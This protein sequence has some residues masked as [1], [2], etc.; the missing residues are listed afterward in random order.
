VATASRISAPECTSLAGLMSDPQVYNLVGVLDAEQ[1]LALHEWLPNK[2]CARC[3]GTG[4]TIRVLGDPS[5]GMIALEV[6]LDDPC[7]CCLGIGHHFVI[8]L[9]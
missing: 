9:S 6:S 8:N 5:R 4:Q 3:M 2:P 1:L 7:A